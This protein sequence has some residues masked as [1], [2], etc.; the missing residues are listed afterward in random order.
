MI[1]LTIGTTEPLDR[2]VVAMD[3]IA[4]LLPDVSIIAQISNS[5]YAVKNMK[6]TGFLSPV[7]YYEL[8]NKAS[9]IISHA[10]MGTILSALQKGKSIIIMPRMVDLGEAKN[11]H[12]IATAIKLAALNYVKIANDEDQLFLLI[13]QSLL[14]KVPEVPSIGPFASAQLINSLKNF[15]NTK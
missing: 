14:E 9:L 11:N 8:F 6:T 4:A 5:S 10:G 1:F 2:L 13:K 3:N 15:I 7:E 12:Q